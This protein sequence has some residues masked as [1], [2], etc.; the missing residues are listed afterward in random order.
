VD[1]LLSEASFLMS[2]D[3]ATGYIKARKKSKVGLVWPYAKNQVGN[4]Y[5][6]LDAGARAL[7]LR[8]KLLTNGSLGFHHGVVTIPVLFET[9]LQD[10]IQWC[11][12]N[13]DELVLLLPSHFEYGNVY[14][15]A[16]DGEDGSIVTKMA[17]LYEK[18]GVAYLKCSD[19]YGFTVGEAFE[20]AQLRSGGYLLALDGQDHYGS[21][22]GKSNW[23]S[24]SIVT[25]WGSSASNT[26]NNVTGILSSCK[27]SPTPLARLSDY[28][29]ASANNPATDDSGQLG[30]PADLY[31]YPFNEI[32]ALWQVSAYS[33][34]MGLAHFSSILEDNKASQV[35]KHMMDLIYADAFDSISLFA[36][37]NVAEN[38]NALLSVLRNRCGQTSENECGQ[39]LDPPPLKYMHFSFR[40]TVCIIIALYALWYTSSVIYYK[41]RSTAAFESSS[42][43]DEDETKATNY[44]LMT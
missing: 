27:T 3:S 6:Q 22:C 26:G 44:G 41:T 17:T 19:V 7:D 16:D 18:Y 38:G 37:D 32:Q 15:Q 23:V 4:V 28:V 25:C 20:A 33:A 12:H 29:L 14:Y 21:Y 24:G 8:V 1:L 35:N 13:P 34:T 39:S 9:L 30:P 42:S 31:S 36:V 10:A 2:H 40:T 5:Q 11:S 43:S